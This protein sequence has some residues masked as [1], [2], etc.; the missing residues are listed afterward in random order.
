MC[1]LDLINVYL[2][3]NS[4]GVA[5][6]LQHYSDYCTFSWINS[7]LIAIVVRIWGI[8]AQTEVWK[9]REVRL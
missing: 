3:G 4:L 2:Y 8:N 9:F 5:D 1:L 6:M 7:G